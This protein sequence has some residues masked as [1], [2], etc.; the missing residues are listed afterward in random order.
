MKLKLLSIGKVRQSFVLEG[1]AEYLK[2][3]K[4]HLPLEMV[5]LDNE[6]LASLPEPQIIERESE[7]MLGRLKAGDY[8]VVLD[9]RGKSL[10]S[11][12]LAELLHS[13]MISGEG[14]CVFAIGGALGWS[15]AAR[16]RADLLLSLSQLTFPYQ[17]TRLILVEQLYRAV[18]IIKR[19]PYHR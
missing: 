17:L 11:E 10:S 3:M 2:R 15:E 12:K 1:E 6:K 8:L 5:E 16:K 14:S 19:L 9:Q 18:T 4:P 7:L 13:R